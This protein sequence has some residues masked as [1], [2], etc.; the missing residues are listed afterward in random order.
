[1]DEEFKLEDFLAEGGEDDFSLVLDN[2]E[3]EVVD[4]PEQ[5][6]DDDEEEPKKED[7]DVDET[8][9]EEEGKDKKPPTQK[10]D[11]TDKNIS[12]SSNSN[13]YSSLVKGLSE[14]GVFK[15]VE[16]GDDNKIENFDDFA[17][18]LDKEIEAR[19]GERIKELSPDEQFFAS[20]R[21]LG[22]NDDEIY[23]QLQTKQG[24]DSITDDTLTA[25]DEKGENL[26]KQVLTQFYKSKGFSDEKVKR[27][28][29]RIFKEGADVDES[30][31]ALEAI[32]GNFTEWEK[33]QDETRQ[34][35]I[36][37][38]TEARDK[39]LNDLKEYA[40]KTK[41]IIPDTPISKKIRDEVFNGMTKP[42][43][44]T[45]DGTNLDI[46]GDFLHKGKLQDRYNLAYLIKVT[47]GLKDF[48]KLSSKKGKSSAISEL[49]KSLSSSDISEFQKSGLDENFFAELDDYSVAE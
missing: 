36:K 11:K 2:E 12:S 23:Q 29:D 44:K 6:A 27:D 47:D 15:F 10:P 42:V 38:Q 28:V 21:Q 35:Q 9:E 45:D 33:Q 17:D 37:E 7:K 34:K 49:E 22:Y 5:P 46:V 32:K 3:E 40:S 13:V 24:L 26:R 19:L 4:T 16:L 8:D 14:E 31:D 20:K 39:A 1:M 25:E 48:S 30:K 18:N 41:E 43:S